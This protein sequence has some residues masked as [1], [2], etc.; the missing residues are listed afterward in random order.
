MKANPGARFEIDG[1]T[2]NLG[3]ANKNKVLSQARADAIKKYFTDKGVLDGQLDAI[4]FGSERPAAD[5]KTPAGRAK[6]RRVE[7]KLAE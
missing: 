3:D 4:G 7:I 6:N 2:D 5:N 1:H